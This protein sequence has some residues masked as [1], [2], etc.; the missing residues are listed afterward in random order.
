M[1]SN[2]FIDILIDEYRV[3]Q[4]QRNSSRPIVVT[5]LGFALATF[6]GYGAVYFQKVDGAPWFMVVAPLGLFL[7]ASVALWN[8]QQEIFLSFYLNAIEGKIRTEL[9]NRGHSQSDVSFDAIPG[10]TLFSSGALLAESGS[11]KH[12][13]GCGAITLFSAVTVFSAAAIVMVFAGYKSV[14]TDPGLRWIKL[15]YCIFYIVIICMLGRYFYQVHFDSRRNFVLLAEKY[16]WRLPENAYF[17]VTKQGDYN[18][19]CIPRPGD[20]SKCIWGVFGIAYCSV[21]YDYPVST[22]VHALVLYV[23]IFE[24]LFYQTRYLVNDLVGF[25]EDVNHPATE[26]RCRVPKDV[27]R[28]SSLIKELALRGLLGVLILISLGWDYPLASLQLSLSLIILV[29]LTWGYELIKCKE[30]DLSSKWWTKSMFLFV[31]LGYVLRFFTGAGLFVAVGSDLPVGD[32]PKVVIF[33]LINFF[34]MY[35]LYLIQ[36]L[37]LS[38]AIVGLTMYS[39][40]LGW[41]VEAVSWVTYEPN[42]RTLVVAVPS[43]RKRHILVVMRRYLSCIGVDRFE[44]KEAEGGVNA[45]CESLLSLKAFICS[46]KLSTE[47]KSKFYLKIWKCPW[48]WGEVTA[49]A[50]MAIYMWARFNYVR[51]LWYVGVSCFVVVVAVAALALILTCEILDCRISIALCALFALG[52][53]CEFLYFRIDGFFVIVF[54]YI[55]GVVAGMG[56]PML[57]YES[58]VKGLN[59]LVSELSSWCTNKSKL[60]ALKIVGQTS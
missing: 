27:D 29:L 21:I 23:A 44:E 7:P 56:I 37:G 13:K 19:F 3:V 33:F 40:S 14:A 30:I 9:L 16:Q 54:M 1:T 6:V 28:V 42:G 22:S 55:L 34:K 49:F 52:L 58:M 32:I 36:G 46:H 50:G 47:G 15:P 43:G 45:V 38:L 57:K 10:L 18:R 2:S 51:P 12:K 31:G 20:L 41:L 53:L 39:V 59:G 11:S 5:I 4:D 17:G 8:A 60:L 24:L 25:Q 26:V 35:N 48:V